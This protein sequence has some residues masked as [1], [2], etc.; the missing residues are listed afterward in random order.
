MNAEPEEGH[1]G[2]RAL[3]AEVDDRL[4]LAIENAVGVLHLAEVDEVEVRFVEIGK[5]RSVAR[6]VGVTLHL[7]QV[8][9]DREPADH[10]Y[11]IPAS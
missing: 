2:D 3:A 4:V 8:L 7:S 1:E 11:S 10:P 6:A 5:I 9:D